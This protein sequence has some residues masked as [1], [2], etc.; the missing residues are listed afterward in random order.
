MDDEIAYDDLYKRVYPPFSKDE[1]AKYVVRTL[2]LEGY[3]FSQQD[4]VSGEI[5]PQTCDPQ[6][7]GQ[8]RAINT[9]KAIVPEPNL[10]FAKEKIT[11]QNFLKRFPFVQRLHKNMMIDIF[12]HHQRNNEHFRYPQYS[13]LGYFRDK[14]KVVEKRVMPQPDRIL[15]LLVEA[16]T[17]Y[18]DIYMKHHDNIANPRMMEQKDWKRLETAAHD[19]GIAICCIKPFEDGSNRVGRLVTNV[20]R[21]NVGLKLETFE[22]HQNYNDVLSQQQRKFK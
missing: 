11:T 22:N 7:A 17:K 1:L 4:V 8:F 14:E 13:D 3:R 5:S 20:C 21:L 6:I 12:L 16:F 10:F 9:V 2:G 19:L 15:P 18:T